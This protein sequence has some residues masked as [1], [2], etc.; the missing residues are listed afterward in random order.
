M[1][2]DS[3]TTEA[4]VREHLRAFLEHEEVDSIVK[5]YHDEARLYGEA[6]IYHGKHEVRG[7]FVDFVGALPVGALE[8]FE[9]RSLQVEGNIAYITWSVGADIPLGTDTFVVDDGKIVSQTF[10]MHAASAH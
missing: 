2:D 8:R 10:A 5:D 1:K 9:L 6:K 4:V 7:F 3:S